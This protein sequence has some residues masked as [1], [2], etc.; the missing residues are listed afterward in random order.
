MEYLDGET[1][2]ARL[3]KGAL[4][5]ADALRI[6]RQIADALTAAHRRGIIHRDLK[7]GNV[8]LTKAGAKLLDFGLAKTTAPAVTD[9]LSMLP[10]SPPGRTVQG[11]ILGTFQYMAPEQ[12]EGWNADARTDIFAFGAVLYE[13]L[14]GRKAFEGKS[15]ASLI[16]AIL[17]DEPPAVASRQ[18]LAPPSLDRVVR[19]CLAKDP[20][21]RWQTAADLT[22]ELK[23]LLESSVLSTSESVAPRRVRRERVLWSTAV[24]LPLV[25]IL[26]L[27]SLWLTHMRETPS[28]GDTVRLPLGLPARTVLTT[29]GPSEWSS[30]S[31]QTDGNWRSRR[32]SMTVCRRSS[33]APLG[34]RSDRH[35][36]VRRARPSRSGCPTA[37]SSASSRT[38]SSRRS[39]WKVAR[40]TVYDAPGGRGGTWNRDKVIVLAADSYAGLVRV[41]ASGGMVTPVTTLDHTRQETFHRWPQF[42]A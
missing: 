2:A 29:F 7:P 15:Q 3:T 21:E 24:A 11:T 14:T 36:P 16:G 27:L 6:A 12:L 32:P 4:P 20:D 41:S 40:Q 17:K 26:A 18:P 38:T 5:L 37:G 8:M 30:R 31:H 19:R 10:T 34:A 33:C 42:S 22:H 35:C 25:A 1:L 28:F 39:T 13:M 23:W 9:G